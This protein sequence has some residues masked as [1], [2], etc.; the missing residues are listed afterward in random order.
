MWYR[1]PNLDNQQINIEE[2]R[3]L[4]AVNVS[5]R[6]TEAEE[7]PSAVPP[8]RARMPLLP[9]IQ[10]Y[11]NLIYSVVQMLRLQVAVYLRVLWKGRGV[12]QM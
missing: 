12:L 9:S 2:Y 1:K 7:K 6:P 4:N 10:R 8:L 5:L 3:L 11:S